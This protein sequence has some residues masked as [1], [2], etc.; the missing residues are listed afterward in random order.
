MIVS[1]LPPDGMVNV[2]INTKVSIVFDSPMSPID[3][4]RFSLRIGAL[5][6]VG[7]IST[8]ADGHTMTFDPEV[9]LAT[10]ATFEGVLRASVTSVE[11][12]ALGADYRWSFSTGVKADL[13]SPEVSS[14]SPTDGMTGV[15]TNMALAITFNESMDPATI[16]AAEFWLTMGETPVAGVVAYSGVVATF[17]P[18]ERLAPNTDY[19]A[20]IVSGATDLAGNALAN[21]YEWRFKTGDAPELVAPTVVA[22]TPGVDAVD[23]PLNQRISLTFSEPM[24]PTS[25]TAATFTLRAGTV[26]VVAT[27]TYSGVSGVL[28][29]RELLAENTEYTATLGIDATD[30]AGNAIPSAHEW[31]FTTGSAIDNTLPL[32]VS[33][34]PINNKVAAGVR[35]NISAIFSEE[36]DPAT[37]NITSMTLMLGSTQV[38]GAVTYSG[39]TAVFEP[40]ASLLP[41]ANYHVAI[42]PSVTDLAGNP[43]ASAFSWSFVT[44]EAHE[45]EAPTVVSTVPGYSAVG[46][47]IDQ[48]MSI[49]FSEAMSPA[50]IHAATF[51]L[52]RGATP[53]VST[54]TY[55]GLTAELAPWEPLAYNTQYTLT[56]ST[57]AVDLVGNALESAHEWRFTTALTPDTIAPTVLSA[58]PLAGVVDAEINVAV[59]V[60]FTEP[61]AG[62]TLNATSLTL[63]R[64]SVPVGAT[65]T[66]AGVV[67]TL[68]PWEVLAYETEYT[69]TLSRAATDLAGNALQSAHEWRF[70]TR[71]EPDTIAPTVITTVPAHLAAN[72]EINQAIIAT[73]SEALAASTIT[74][75]SMTLYRGTTPISATVTFAGVTATLTPL[76]ELEYETEYT[77]GFGPD[78]SDLSGNKL[79][80]ANSW[81]FTTRIAPDIIAPQVVSASPAS[82]ASGAAAN[83]GV[84]VTFDEAMSA[85]TVNALSFQVNDDSL[86]PVP[87]TVT[88][89]ATGLVAT[90][91]PTTD[92]LRGS[93]YHVALSTALT[94]VAGNPLALASAWDFTTA[95]GPAPVSLGAAAN[96]VIFA[97]TGITTTGV[98]DVTGNLGLSP[99]VDA[100]LAGWGQSAATTF[101]T[102]PMVDGHIHVSTYNAP[103]PANLIA[104]ST[105]MGAAYSA[106]AAQGPPDAIGLNA[107]ALGGVTFAPGIYRWSAAA[108][109][110]TDV[111][112]DGGPNDVW[113]FQ[114]NGALAM[115]ASVSV[116]LTGGA[117]P[118]NV[119]W[120]VNG[121]IN[122]GATSHFVGIALAATAINVGA[123]SSVNGRLL[124]QTAVTIDTCTIGI[125][126]P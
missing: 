78:V 111:T 75:T 22:N 107:G 46:V 40:S 100:V 45:T 96:Y 106:V 26:P 15:A 119:F 64:G 97:R 126:T 68:V 9:D 49:T 4:P 34:I 81:Q 89:D 80:D 14:T 57:G 37:V 92:F 58:T 25:V 87:G 77:V 114:I 6:V 48:K 52:R 7:A 62:A 2:P 94:D 105:D 38:A 41:D 35:Q 10:G 79:A 117:R 53:I 101:S 23:V 71:V 76:L 43:M 112:I 118:E 82:G 116:V 13:T 59:V 17:T 61:M 19:T 50:S 20:E 39:L 109:I 85:G 104:A 93:T 70:T 86:A 102:S 31:R 11:G 8:S 113:V 55:L 90:F 33:T 36:L 42:A 121:A 16:T 29:P 56:M 12:M 1:T 54:I 99:G 69:A 5:D 32:V 66:Y 95:A 65:V 44:G 67:A 120:Q 18:N 91:A 24:A 73:F 115:A 51:T 30:L 3:Q 60:T 72:V 108:T 21:S 123:G 125:T 110:A 124:A 27:I 63:R 28:A 83:E 84:V 88:L 103:T 47:P 98:S 74:N 122:I